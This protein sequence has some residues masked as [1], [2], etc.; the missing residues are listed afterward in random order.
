MNSLALNFS[1]W[2]LLR[3]RY[4]YLLM[5]LPIL[6]MV[7]AFFVLWPIAVWMGGALG[8]PPDV[9]VRDQPNGW[10]WFAL[11]CVL[12]AVFITVGNIVGFVLNAVVAVLLGWPKDK[13]IAVFGHSKV[14]NHWLL[15]PEAP[16][17]ET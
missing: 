7:G 13:V 15:T 16:Q 14:P 11:F 2:Y 17:D 6:C 9:P 8:I 4:I 3:Q 10:L 1:I 12:F 5:V